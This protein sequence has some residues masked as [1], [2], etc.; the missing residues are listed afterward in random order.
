MTLF[1]HLLELLVASR[2]DFWRDVLYLFRGTFFSRFKWF[3]R[4]LALVRGFRF[5]Q[6]AQSNWLV[7]LF[8]SVSE[9]PSFFF[10]LNCSSLTFAGRRDLIFGCQLSSLI[11]GDLASEQLIILLISI[12]LM[13]KIGGLVSLHDSIFVENVIFFVLTF[14]LSASF[15]YLFK[16]DSNAEQMP[17]AWI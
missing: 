5:F 6:I 10:L 13:L 11:M 1:L 4:R 7:L 14:K 9:L 16:D 8:L 2:A 12:Q 15:T 3:Y 17:H